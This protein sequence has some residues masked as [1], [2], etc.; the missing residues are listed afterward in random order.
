M[1]G[2]DSDADMVKRAG[3]ENDF[4]AGEHLGA[5][6]FADALAE[7]AELGFEAIG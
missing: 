5:V 7:Q 3:I 6:I 4:G 2:E 1:L